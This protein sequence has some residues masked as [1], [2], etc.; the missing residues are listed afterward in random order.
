[1]I[2]RWTVRFRNALTSERAVELE[3]ALVERGRKVIAELCGPTS[4]PTQQ[5]LNE[6][7][8]RISVFDEH[9]AIVE[10]EFPSPSVAIGNSAMYDQLGILGHL[11]DLFEVEDLQGLPRRHWFFLGGSSPSQ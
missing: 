10:T 3:Q 7:A 11:N 5:K 8:V 6:P 1:M 9:Y 2:R 4:T